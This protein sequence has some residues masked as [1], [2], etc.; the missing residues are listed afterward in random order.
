MKNKGNVVFKIIAY[1]F[2][3]LLLVLTVYP[4]IYALLCSF[5]NTQ[6]I[7]VGS[8]F[9]P[10]KFEFK[11]Y[12]QAWKIANFAK[13]TFNSAWYSVFEVLIAIW[14][15]TIAGYVFA[16]GEFRG[17]K[18]IFACFT[19][20][21]FITLGTS[22]L[23]PKLQI[24]KLLHL[25]NSL[26]G[27]LVMQFFGINITNVFLVRGFVVSLPKAL[28]EAAEIDGCSFFGTFIRIILPLLKPIIAT[29]AIFSFAIA[30]NDYLLPMVVTL[31]NPAQ[32][33]LSV[34]MIAL[35]GSAEAATAWNLILAGAMISAIPM[36]I[37]FLCF[38]KFFIKGLSSGA[39]KG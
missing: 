28:D 12:V 26:F 7:L 24:L 13:Y 35:K 5:K 11:N 27:L 32:R 4:F 6:E 18:I 2:L 8:S 9:M 37:V 14:T 10:K 17:K 22:T 38:N 23:Y 16:R 39:V 29:V 30:W 21:M 19:S 31:A 33:P 1:T 3:I 36:I 15:S 34:G 25:N 20:L